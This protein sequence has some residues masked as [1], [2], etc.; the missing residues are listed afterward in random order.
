MKSQGAF[1]PDPKV[2]WLLELSQ[3]HIVTDAD[4]ADTIAIDIL[5]GT[6]NGGGVLAVDESFLGLL[7]GL[8]DC[9]EKVVFKC[10]VV[11][12]EADVDVH[13]DAENIRVLEQVNWYFSKRIPCSR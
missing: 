1:V 7:K 10:G 3:R 6:A 4:D 9:H 5:Q 12:V 2:Y 13:Y 11:G 8:G